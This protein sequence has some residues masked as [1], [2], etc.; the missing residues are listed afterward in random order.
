MSMDFT[1]RAARVAKAEAEE[2]CPD[3]KLSVPLPSG[4]VLFDQFF[5]AD[6][7]PP[8]N[9]PAA[10]PTA[11]PLLFAV[12]HFP[13]ESPLGVARAVTSHA[14]AEMSSRTPLAS[15]ADCC[16]PN[17]GVFSDAQLATS[18]SQSPICRSAA[19]ARGAQVYGDLAA[20]TADS[21]TACQPGL[22][23]AS[24]PHSRP[25]GRVLQPQRRW[26]M[27]TSIASANSLVFFVRFIVKTMD[28]A[29]LFKFNDHE[30]SS[31]YKPITPVRQRI[32]RTTW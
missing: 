5:T 31:H 7:I 21:R 26:P 28:Y 11:I 16:E 1:L 20:R 2:L 4:R 13:D 22:K 18:L 8:V 32:C 10:A 25:F 14:A 6:V 30:R 9:R 27:L 19:P 17:T 24:C 12:S 23:V 3:G 29:I 15:R